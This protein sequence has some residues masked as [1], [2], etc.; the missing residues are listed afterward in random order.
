[1]RFRPPLGL[2]DPM[3]SSALRARWGEVSLFDESVQRAWLWN[4]GMT[5]VLGCVQ[6]CSLPFS[7]IKV[8]TYTF[9]W[10]RY[11]RSAPRR[12]CPASFGCRQRLHVLS[13]RHVASGETMPCRR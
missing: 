12:P 1:M 10:G 8:A 11:P 3:A 5:M 9:S 4:C 13:G 6:V 7:A 2:V